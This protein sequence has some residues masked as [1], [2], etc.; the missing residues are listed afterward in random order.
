MNLSDLTQQA[1]SIQKK[2]DDFNVKNGRKPWGLADLT[3]G[4]VGDTG[5]LCKLIMA[6]AGIRDI[7]DADEKLSH[8]L[9]DCFWSILVISHACGID[10]ETAFQ[11]TMTE[12]EEKLKSSESSSIPPLTQTA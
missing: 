10:L 2:F 6:K 5:D 7:R 9:A 8:E 1:L 11:Q 4:F 3:M 12:I